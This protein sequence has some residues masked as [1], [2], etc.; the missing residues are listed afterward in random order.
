MERKARSLPSSGPVAHRRFQTVVQVFVF[1]GEVFLQT[2]L[3]A[4]WVPVVVGRDVQAGLQL[5][6]D[7]VSRE[8][9]RLTGV[10]GGVLVEDLGS[11]NGTYVNGRRLVGRQTV[12]F[13]DSVRVGP[14]TL[15]VRSLRGEGLKTIDPVATR[16]STRTDARARPDSS[17]EDTEQ[18]SLSERILLARPKTTDIVRQRL[19]DLDRL[20]ETL[21]DAKPVA[22]ANAW[23]TEV[24]VRG[25]TQRLAEDMQAGLVEHLSVVPDVSMDLPNTDPGA[26]PC[27]LGRQ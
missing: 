24:D 13:H 2:E 4:P 19:R 14:Y 25:Y 20:I 5:S 16:A 1:D 3:F 17:E 6:A 9:C 15:K 12:A 22:A 27:N 10:D 7:R 23:T 11:G 8:H 26:R 18:G 21:D